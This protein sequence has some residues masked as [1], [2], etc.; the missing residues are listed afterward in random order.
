MN[1]VN[2]R[3]GTTETLAMLKRMAPCR[4]VPELAEWRRLVK[5]AQAAHG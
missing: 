3:S 2:W 5:E 1:W 4:V